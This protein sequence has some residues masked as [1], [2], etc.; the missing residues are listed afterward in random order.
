MTQLGQPVIDEWYLFPICVFCLVLEHYAQLYCHGEVGY[1]KE[2]FLM[3]FSLSFLPT[4][5]KSSLM[6][7][8][9]LK[10]W[11]SSCCLPLSLDTS[12]T[13]HDNTASPPVMQPYSNHEHCDPRSGARLSKVSI[14]YIAHA[15]VVP[16][17]LGIRD[18]SHPAYTS[19]QCLQLFYCSYY[20]TLI[21][22]TS[23]R[24]QNCPAH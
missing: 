15:P 5:T 1:C 23:R 17:S 18:V 19:V 8:V 3:S 12:Q 24:H 14:K 6:L 10:E 20:T 7:M 16:V 21:E 9:L 13:G 11:F 2:V 22:A 4:N